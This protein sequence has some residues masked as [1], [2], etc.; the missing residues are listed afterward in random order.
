MLDPFAQHRRGL[1]RAPLA[2]VLAPGIVDEARVRAALDRRQGLVGVACALV[3]GQGGGERRRG[4]DLPRLV[5][6]LHAYIIARPARA[7]SGSAPARGA[8]CSRWTR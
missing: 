6:G 5:S 2:Y 3:F 8:V 4:L 1:A 7:P